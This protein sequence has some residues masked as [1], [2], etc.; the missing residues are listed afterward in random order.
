MTF[1]L[2]VLIAGWIGYDFWQILKASNGLRPENPAFLLFL[3]APYD[4]FR[5]IKGKI[6]K[7]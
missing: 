4:L 6:K 1:V 7:A 5:F 3:A 2:F